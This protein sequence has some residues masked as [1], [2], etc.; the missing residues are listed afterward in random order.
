VSRFQ[1]PAVYLVATLAGLLAAQLFVEPTHALEVPPLPTVTTPLPVPP[2]TT[3]EPLPTPP[4]L[5]APTPPPLPPLDPVPALPLPPPDPA[6]LPAPTPNPLSSPSAPRVSPAGA[7]AAPAP[8]PGP[9]AET[10]SASST[11]TP[12]T[13][14][15]AAPASTSSGWSVSSTA[16]TARI[17]ASQPGRLRATPRRLKGLVTVRLRF[18]LASAGRLFLVVRGPVPSCRIVAAIPVRGRKGLNT[19]DFRG[20]AAGRD[21]R[22]GTYSLAV[23]TE[24]RPPAGTPATLVRVVSRARTVPVEGDTAPNC[25]AARTFADR[26]FDPLLRSEA[27]V[28]HRLATPAK[29]Q[30]APRSEPATLPPAKGDD[31]HD[32][33]GIAIPA[34]FDGDGPSGPLETL[35]SIAI[36]TLIGALLLTMVTLVTR[37][38]RGTWN[39]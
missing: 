2:P 5:P 31:Q 30:R 1:K 37:F 18:E 35:I 21:L 27:T 38:F 11:S 19:L 22:P 26:R 23:S 28:A 17:S 39:P 3:T 36:L 16:R 6:P 32:V 14:P 20:R 34:P 7:P 24:R 4:T 29:A 9:G 33:L 25:T 10:A 12:A 8:A 15:A 13:A